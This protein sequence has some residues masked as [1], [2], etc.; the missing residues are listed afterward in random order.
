MPALGGADVD[1]FVITVRGH[2]GEVVRAVFQQFDIEIEGEHTVLRGQL[3]DQ[4]ALQGV[5]Q[6]MQDYGIEIIEVRR[7]PRGASTPDDDEVGG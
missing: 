7:E 5:L 1:S 2:A 4:A 3:A 6:R